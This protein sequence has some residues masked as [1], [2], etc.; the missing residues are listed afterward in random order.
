[1]CQ[2]PA[3]NNMVEVMQEKIEITLSDAILIYSA[4][5]QVQQFFQNP[6]NFENVEEFASDVYPLLKKVYYEIFDGAFD[7]ETEEWLAE[8][9]R[10]SLGLD[11]IDT[12]GMPPK[13]G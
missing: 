11:Y 6:D 1:M 5:E 3:L 2:R 7:Q 9:R 10:N 13:D 12:R 4:I 8:S